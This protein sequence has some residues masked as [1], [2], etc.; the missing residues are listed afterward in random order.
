MPVVTNSEIQYQLIA[1]DGPKPNTQL[2]FWRD[3]VLD[4]KVPL[5]VNLCETVGN[6]GN[7][8]NGCCWYW[9]TTAEPLR[10]DGDKLVVTMENA[11]PACSTLL[12]YTLNVRQVLDDGSER[13]A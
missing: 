1:C 11:L 3:L 4:Y 8:Y 10:I 13:T 12:Q 5:I 2:S 7:F 6:S 9:P